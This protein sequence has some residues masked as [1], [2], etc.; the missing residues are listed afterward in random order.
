M[1]LRPKDPEA[2]LERQRERRR[3]ATSRYLEN[4]RARRLERVAKGERVGLERRGPIARVNRDR[5]AKLHVR[6]FAGPMGDYDHWIRA[7]RSCVS[8]KRG[9]RFDPMVASHTEARGMGGCGGDWTKLVPMLWSENQDYSDLPDAKWEAKYG[10]TK[11]EV[12]AMAP[13]YH[14]RYLEEAAHA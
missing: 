6:N 13:V 12:C 8:G 11:A 4:L 14:A 1:T 9:T 3:R 10:C 5:R 2:A 7:H